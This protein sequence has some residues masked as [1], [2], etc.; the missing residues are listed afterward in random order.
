MYHIHSTLKGEKYDYKNNMKSYVLN[1]IEKLKV[2]T[3]A[4]ERDLA[5]VATGMV[6]GQSQH[7]KNTG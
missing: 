5:C 3:T 6:L 1:L 4:E 2:C 7:D